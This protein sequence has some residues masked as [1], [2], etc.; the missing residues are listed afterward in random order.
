M[1]GWMDGPT[2]M[3]NTDYAHAVNLMKFNPL[4]Q[5]VNKRCTKPIFKNV[6]FL[7]WADKLNRFQVV[8]TFS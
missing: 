1:D 5:I 4:I 2:S 3:S 7:Y 6:S 8:A